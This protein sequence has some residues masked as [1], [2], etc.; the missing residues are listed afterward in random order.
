LKTS[1]I[2][3]MTVLYTR[4]EGPTR[5]G[6]RSVVLDTATWAPTRQGVGRFG[7]LLGF[8]PVTGRLAQGGHSGERG[9]LVLVEDH[10]INDVSDEEM[11]TL[12][13]AALAAAHTGRVPSVHP[14]MT[15]TTVAAREI[16][17]TWEQYSTEQAAERPDPG[18]RCR[19]PLAAGRRAR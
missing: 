19:R 9:M 13:E 17:K 18:R 6:R 4:Q 12:A 16:T 14:R 5:L 1:D 7:S 10:G 8:A 11:F 15:V 3:P 2:T